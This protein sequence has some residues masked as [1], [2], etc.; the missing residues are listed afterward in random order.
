M[1]HPVALAYSL[2]GQPTEPQAFYEAACHPQRDVVVEACAGAGKTWI[3]VSR[4]VRA[5]LD[6]VSPS[7]ILAITFTRKAAGEMQHRLESLLKEFAQD[8]ETKRIAQLQMRGMDEAQARQYAPALGQ[9]YEQ[10]LGSCEQPRISTIHGWFSGLIRGLPLDVLAT[11][12]LP[13]Q[14]QLLE[15]AEAHWPDVWQMFLRRLHAQQGTP[16]HQ[17]LMQEVV[18]VIGLSNF[19]KWMKQALQQRMEITLA[20]QAGNLLGSVPPVSAVFPVFAQFAQVCDCLFDPAN[21][22][23]LENLAR[24]LGQQAGKISATQI[25]LAAQIIDAYLVDDSASCYALLKNAFL[26]QAGEPK[27]LRGVKHERLQEAQALLVD[28]TAALR[29]QSAHGQHSAMVWASHVLFDAYA[30]FKQA[31][32]LVDMVDLELAAARLHADD[33]LAGWVHERLD[34]RIRHLLVDEFQDTSPVQWQVLHQWISAYAGSGGGHALRVFLVGD[35]KQS[36]Y[37]FRRADPRVFRAASLFVTQEL[38]GVHLACDHTRRNAQAVIEAVNR[39]MGHTALTGGFA[40]YRPHTTESSLLGCVLALP[41]IQRP[42]ADKR[43]A[44]A[45]ASVE[46]QQAEL[47]MDGWRDSLCQAKHEPK[48]ALAQKEA[49]QMAQAIAHLLGAPQR[50]TAC[51]PI[52]E[53]GADQGANAYKPGDIFVLSRRRKDLEWMAEA[54]AELGIPHVFPERTVLMETPEAQDLLAVLECLVMPWRDLALARALKSPAFG[55][56]DQV[57]MALA[58][59]LQTVE[60][61]GE[62]GAWWSS[63]M[64]M[65]TEGLLPADI[66][67]V[68]KARQ[69]LVRWRDQTHHLPPHDL[70]QQIVD[71]SGWVSALH[72]ALSPAM[73]RQAQI[74]LEAVVAESLMLRGGRDATPLGWWRALKQHKAKLPTQAMQGVVQLLTV[75]GAKGLEAN[76]V[77]ILNADPKEPVGSAYQLM[78]DWPP[79]SPAP[80]TCAFVAKTAELAPS[81]LPLQEKQKQVQY[82]E[83]CN[84]LYVAMTR[85]QQML[86][87]SRVVPASTRSESMS[88]WQ[89]LLASQALQDAQRWQ[90]PDDA[91]QAYLETAHVGKGASVRVLPALSMPAAPIKGDELP[92]TTLPQSLQSDDLQAWQGRVFHRALEWATATSVEQ[93]TRQ[94]VGHWVTKAADTLPVPASVSQGLPSNWQDAVLDQV[95]QVLQHPGNQAWLD[96][97]RCDWA[98]NEVELWHE[99][100]LMRLDR[101]VAH[102][103]ADGDLHWWAIDFKMHDNPLQVPA[104]VNQV[105]AYVKAVAAIEPQAKVSGAFINRKGEWLPLLSR[106]HHPGAP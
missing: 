98:G 70:L 61:G 38:R 16:A 27:S 69:L 50:P 31:E 103:E 24:D 11:L 85:A 34:I 19:E 101:L 55:A 43:A 39:V 92:V 72:R 77:C 89:H 94:R 47:E 26:T 54:L 32:G 29:Q 76:V 13:P 30:A 73:A 15:D 78:V 20:H 71:E 79:Q 2:N 87:F 10:W 53:S 75:H 64:D 28:I 67:C 22:N 105:A 83:E 46:S 93:R 100:R 84:A 35:P 40:A 62:G 99:G 44:N 37:G 17:L 96:P 45:D 63:L 65:P 6:G 33:A 106:D 91:V 49:Q 57:L 3:L 23:F 95:W 81:L 97:A 12:G 4:M 90:L 68:D 66:A 1:K 74:Y 51:I 82:L 104:Y 7:S 56:S 25:K 102:R 86:I 59:H 88:W 41:D 8:T 5:L 48:E 80:T 18:G 36:I 60:K 9:L 58:R 42:A 21:R 14:W 52:G